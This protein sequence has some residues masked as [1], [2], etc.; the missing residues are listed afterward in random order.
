MPCKPGGPL[1]PE[2]IAAVEQFVAYLA[3]KRDAENRGTDV[4]RETPASEPWTL[5]THDEG[6]DSK[7][8]WDVDHPPAP[9]KEAQR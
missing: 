5:C 6:H 8:S 9:A 1:Q 2:D 4:C 3:A 7:H